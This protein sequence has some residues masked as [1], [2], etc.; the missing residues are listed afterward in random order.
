MW[1]STF[2]LKPLKQFVM[3]TKLFVLALLL[4][5]T[6]GFTKSTG[7]DVIKGDSMTSL[8]EYTIQEAIYPLEVS[9]TSFKTLLLQYENA[10]RP[11]QIGIETKKKCVNFIIKGPNFEMEYICNR[12]TFG[13]KSISSQ[14][15][16]IN[17]NINLVVLDAEQLS[18]QRV[19]SISEKTEKELLGLIACYLPSLIKEKYRTQI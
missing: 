10:E 8:G 19:I 4:C 6:V 18:A 12:K 13:A 14:Y 2:V 3:K 17:E 15:Q 11:I 7:S 1:L 5:Y 9:G 16:E